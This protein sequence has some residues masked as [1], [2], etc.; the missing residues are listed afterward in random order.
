MPYPHPPHRLCRLG[1]RLN[2]ADPLNWVPVPT[3]RA[4]GGS[5][6]TCCANGTC[7]LCPADAKF[8]I[9]NGV[10]KFDYPGAFLLPDTEV[11]RVDIAAGHTTGVEVRRSDGVRLGIAAGT[12]ALATNAI[13]NTAILMRS[14]VKAEALGRYLHEQQSENCILDLKDSALF[15]GTSIPTH[16]VAFRDGPFRANAGSVLIEIYN[17]PT[18]LRPEPG[19]QTHRALIK[20]I[21]EDLP[22]PQNRVF[23]EDDD[24]RI[25]WTGHS[26]YARR[27]L[28]RVAEG[29]ID[30]LPF[31]VDGLT[32][33]AITETESHI[34]G[35]HR[36]GRDPA[37][38]V[39]DSMSRVHGI[40]GLLAL[41][42]GVFPTS[43]PSNPTLTLSALSLMAGRAL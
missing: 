41:G 3:A 39:V 16:G 10:D 43:S 37:T 21:A 35:T 6:P 23:L 1:A 12:V 9:W 11:R 33:L 31:P 7:Y 40:K 26:D 28:D 32:R 24:V 42:A 30:S 22:Q 29:L 15:G 34:Q 13:F 27:G 36:M 8:T 14:G 25:T 4:N 38:S 19:R 18:L 2:E 20:L 17:S 5:R